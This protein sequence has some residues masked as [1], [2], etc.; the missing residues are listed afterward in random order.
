MGKLFRCRFDTRWIFSTIQPRLTTQARGGLGGANV[1]EHGL[2]SVQWNSSPIRANQAEQLMLDAIPLGSPSGI[3]CNRDRQ[4]ELIRE[5]LQAYFPNPTRVPVRAATIRL[6]QQ[7]F[8]VWI[9]FASACGPPAPDRSHRKG[10][11]I[12]RSADDHIP[13]VASD[14]VD[15]VRQRFAQCLIR[16]IIHVHIAWLTAPRASSVLEIANQLFFLRIH[17]EYGAFLPHETFPATLNVLEL[18]IAS[19]NL[20]AFATFAIGS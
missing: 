3:M 19:W 12:V 8:C 10:G 13:F 5:R 15:A 11:R 14:V 17:A 16:E 20:F 4:A 1:F 6:K 2:E 18:F 9:D 7:V